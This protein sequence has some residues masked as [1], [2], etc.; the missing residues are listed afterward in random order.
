MGRS[1]GIDFTI[2][3]SSMKVSTDVCETSQ[4]EATGVGRIPQL[5][6]FSVPLSLLASKDKVVCRGLLRL[7]CS[8]VV[9]RTAQRAALKVDNRE[10]TDL[11]FVAGPFVAL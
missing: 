3:L 5:C 7:C 10:L 2:G 1:T 9:H 11:A 4:R 6:A 8:R